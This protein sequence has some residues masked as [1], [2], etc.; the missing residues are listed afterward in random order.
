M[1]W[2]YTHPHHLPHPSLTI[3]PSH[4]TERIRE[5]TTHRGRERARALRER[6]RQP[7]TELLPTPVSVPQNQMRIPRCVSPSTTYAS[8]LRHP[9]QTQYAR[10]GRL[11]HHLSFPHAPRTPMRPLGYGN[12]IA[13]PILLPIPQSSPTAAPSPRA[14][15]RVAPKLFPFHSNLFLVSYYLFF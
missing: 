6:G 13:N 15:K 10:P 8:L 2:R 14:D 5:P 12:P 4:E 9:K 3:Q 11:S 7:T 1:L